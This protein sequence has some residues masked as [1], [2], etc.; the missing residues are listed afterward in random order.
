MTGLLVN[1]LYF[2][3]LDYS[4]LTLL[5]FSLSFHFF[6]QRSGLRLQSPAQRATTREVG[7]GIRQLALHQPRDAAIAESVSQPRIELASTPRLLA[8]STTV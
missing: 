3:A 2:P 5:S 8:A 1:R 6:H 4:L 7:F